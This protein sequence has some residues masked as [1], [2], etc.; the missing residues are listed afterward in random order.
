M[1][2][3]LPAPI[4]DLQG[5][6]CIFQR[7]KSAAAA[8]CCQ[9]PAWHR[10]PIQVRNVAKC[11]LIL[12]MC[13]WFKFR[14]GPSYEQHDRWSIHCSEEN[15][16][17]SFIQWNNLQSDLP[18]IIRKSGDSICRMDHS[19]FLVL[20]VFAVETVALWCNRPFDLR[21]LYLGTRRSEERSD[22]YA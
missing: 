6:G 20:L 14:S 15:N 11:F 2:L 13:V 5:G 10:L 17:V 12:E 3:D 22:V 8:S 18:V 16:E 1:P 4:T 7:S 21:R 19:W 9:F